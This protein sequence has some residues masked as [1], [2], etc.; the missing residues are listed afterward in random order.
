MTPYS[1][2]QT[3]LYSADENFIAGR[4]LGM[5][6]VFL[7]QSCG[8]TWLGFEQII[9]T[10]LLQELIQERP[11]SY[12]PDELA[13]FAKDYG[14]K[15]EKLLASLE[16]VHPQVVIGIYKERLQ[17][18][19]EFYW[20]RYPLHNPGAINLNRAPLDDLYFRLRDRVCPEAGRSL[21]EQIYIRRRSQLQQEAGDEFAFM[22]NPFFR[23][24]PF[25]S[26]DIYNPISG[27]VERIEGYP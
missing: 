19:Y 8:S 24:R 27:N 25:E 7:T 2:L 1:H 22:R 11:Q 17:Q 23:P 10:L 12:S 21:M 6:T 18:V 16:L 13:R 9:K 14:H 20:R 26:H 3:W 5:T 15:I 4:G